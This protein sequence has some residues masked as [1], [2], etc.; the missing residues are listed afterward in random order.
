[1]SA[2]IHKVPVSRFEN[3]CNLIGISETT[4][5]DKHKLF[6]DGSSSKNTC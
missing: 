3:I 2:G 6:Q 1:M 5:M 4:R